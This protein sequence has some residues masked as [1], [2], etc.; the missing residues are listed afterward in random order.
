MNIIVSHAYSKENKGDAALLSVLLNDLKEI[1]SKAKITILTEDKIEMSETFEGVPIR[2][3]FSYEA[4]NRYKN[5]FL[6]LLYSLFIMAST[7]LWAYVY[8]IS[9]KNIWIPKNIREI[10]VLYSEADLI[11]SV[12]G[13][14]IR[15]KSGIIDTFTFTLLLHPI[16]MAHVLKKPT[17]MYPQSIGPFF[18]GIQR[19][20]AKLVLSKVEMIVLREDIS[21]EILKNLGIRHNI[22][23]SVDSGFLFKSDIKRK[24][25]D[26]FRI[27]AQRPLVGITARLWMQEESQTAYEKNLALFI[28]SIIEKH[29]AFVVFIAQVTATNLK[30]DD[31]LVNSNIY[32]HLKNKG[33]AALLNENYDH[34]EIKAVYNNLD[35]LVGTRFHSVIF[36]LTANVP[37]IAIEYEHKTT[38]IM[39]DLGLVKWVVPI[40]NVNHKDMA[41]LFN[42][43]V[44]EKN[45]YKEILKNKMQSYLE[46]AELTK[47]SLKFFIH[48]FC[49]SKD[50]KI[51]NNKQRIQL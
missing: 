28:D 29:G 40:E 46:K 9:L 47:K 13:G 23:R 37:C 36:A 10:V 51:N 26:E 19:L 22:I 25:R 20:L 1:D 5:N 45:E 6:K 44:E 12:G 32:G 24:L 17:F 38:G 18:N 15:S 35:F 33:G 34:F 2:S 50:I 39:K 21:V 14:Y 8:R 4:L 30:D 11:V 27:S 7:L 16:F 42:Q 49:P 31:R 43:L 48:K 3:T 41:F